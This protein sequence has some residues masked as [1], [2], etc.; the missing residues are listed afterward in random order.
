MR[1][2]LDWAAAN[3]F[4]YRLEGPH[5][6]CCRPMPS[7]GWLSSPPRLFDLI[8]LDPPTFSNPPHAD[9][10]DTQRDHATPDRHC[11]RLL[12]PAECCC[13]HRCQHFEMDS[14]VRQ[15]SRYGHLRAHAAFD[16]RAIR[17]FIA[18]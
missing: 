13:F 9:I 6:R 8:F 18:V 15:I 7:A 10:L 14:A 11:M 12:A 2:Y 16:F 4:A 17:A 5:T 1:T 3:L